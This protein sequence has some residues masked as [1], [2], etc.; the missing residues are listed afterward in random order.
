[1]ST[2][3]FVKTDCGDLSCHPGI[4]FLADILVINK[5]T[6]VFAVLTGY[7]A[8]LIIFVEGALTD[9][10]KITGTIDA[11]KGVISF[12]IPAADTDNYV[13]GIYSYQINLTQGANI[14]R[15]AQGKFEVS[16]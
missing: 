6:G 3:D 14:F 16:R 11:T 10:D 8:E 9:I 15:L 7:T 1:M 13:I 5:C 2:L 12:S 4:T